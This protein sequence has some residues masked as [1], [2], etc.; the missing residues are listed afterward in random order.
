MEPTGNELQIIKKIEK[1][2][3]CELKKI[4]AS[5]FG[6][7]AASNRDIRYGYLL[8][9]QMRVIGL[10]LE[11]LP[12]SP[13]LTLIA[14]LTFLEHLILR[15]VKLQEIFFLTEL[16]EGLKSLDLSSNEKIKDY[17]FI[18][19]LK[20]LTSLYLR[21][22]NLRD[23]SWLKEL[24]C[25]TSLDLS[26][27]NFIK[28][29]S[30]LAEFK[31]LTSL[32]LR[33]NN[34]S[35]VSFLR[36]LDSLAALDLGG[37]NLRDT[38]FLT[39]LKNLK[40]LDLSWNRKIKDYSL[41]KELKGLEFLKLRENNLK[42]S[43]IGFL[44]GLKN[45]T[46][47]ALGGNSL[48]DASFL[49]E[50]P[51]LTSLDMRRNKLKDVSFLKDMDHL[52]YINFDDNP[53][54]SPPREI[55]SQGLQS[56]RDYFK[57][58]EG[59]KYLLKELKVL[60][61]GEGG[62]GKTSLLKR[63]KEK[64]INRN[65]PQTHGINIEDMSI[66]IDGSDAKIHLWDFGGQDIMHASH[67]FFLSKRSLYIL[68]TDCRKEDKIEHWLNYI[69]SFGG[70]SPVLVA[71]NKIDQ[72]PSFDV[73]RQHLQEK[74]KNIRGFFRISCATGSGVEKFFSQMIKEIETVEYMRTEWAKSWFNVKEHLQHMKENYITYDRFYEICNQ[75]HV[76]D[77]SQQQTLLEFLHNLGVILHFKAFE[78]KDYQVLEPKWVTE[79]VYKIINSE[80]LSEEK[81]YL[82]KDML[83][84][85]LNI[86]TF[87]K[88]EYH[89]SLKN[90]LY[91][92]REQH[93]IISLMKIFKLCYSID[94]QT[95]LVPDLL[96]VQEPVYVK[97]IDKKNALK[98]LYEFDFLP[99]SL[100][101]RF[102][103]DMNH[104]IKDKD[105]QWRTGV[106]LKN[107]NT[108]AAAVV[109]AD[110]EARRIYIYVIGNHKEK[111]DYLS[112]IRHCFKNLIQ[113]FEK[114]EV[115]EKVPL[116]DNEKIV[117]DYEEL[118]GYEEAN[119]DEYFVGKLKKSYSIR[120][121]LDGIE[122]PI[123]RELNDYQD[124]HSD[125][126]QSSS[127]YFAPQINLN[128]VAS[129]SSVAESRSTSHVELNIINDLKFQFANLKQL[130]EDADPELKKQLNDV[131]NEL[132]SL[133]EGDDKDKSKGPLTKLGN[134]LKELGDE[135]SG[136][137]KL[138]KGAKKVM[139]CAQTIGKTYNKFSEWIP[140]LPH[141]P[142]ILLG[143][144]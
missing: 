76:T 135:K 93:Y 77:K 38:G 105:S 85:I 83:E 25:L 95:L 116:P 37:N 45:L 52:E 51:R 140:G 97:T 69:R 127:I 122:S 28:N 91:N 118:K 34:L 17:S 61:V 55:V 132:D 103:V 98:F 82:H 128:A 20:N 40:A 1:L 26:N 111:R 59:E 136:Y 39:G 46:K 134:L 107:E 74:Y 2:I 42:F 12:A 79:A 36:G 109:K 16:K 60:L 58:L 68:V 48:S 123:R 27:N 50:L 33:N 15:E 24:K 94:E 47:L 137:S 96:G 143:K 8:D 30:C 70:A 66:S 113:S 106:V 104:D 41:L 102:I 119:R 35:N 73:N 21:K 125:P 67:Q 49:K 65:E 57:S 63:L 5:K 80:K 117:I 108:G 13:P 10:R 6:K 92:A 87:D 43:D 129:S 3:G 99:P 81:G 62:A 112:V 7:R 54:N 141:I 19:G 84:Y 124:H 142:N 64:E 86:E 71:I 121:L 44:T 32:K 139:E 88:E 56:I 115:T 90:T 22:N 18:T 100:I 53:V 23:V 114:L 131:A 110:K 14:S 11:F 130:I 9:R 101:P 133:D 4:D 138:L 75:Y 89:S 126:G 29:L 31:G 72:N 120:Q 78:L 144:K